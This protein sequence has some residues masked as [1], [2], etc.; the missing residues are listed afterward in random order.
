MST[1]NRVDTLIEVMDTNGAVGAVVDQLHP[2]E[3]V[4]R[5]ETSNSPKNVNKRSA[6]AANFEDALQNLKRVK[7]R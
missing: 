7:N 2:S 4:L 3:D 1:S 5:S 6:A